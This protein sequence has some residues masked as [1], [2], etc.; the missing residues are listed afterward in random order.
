MDSRASPAEKRLER[1]KSTLGQIKIKELDDF[2]EHNFRLSFNQPR[3]IRTQGGAAFERLARRQPRKTE[4]PF[5]HSDFRGLIIP[6]YQE[7]VRN[8]TNGKLS[9]I[10]G[11]EK[12]TLEASL[13]NCKGRNR[14]SMTTREVFPIPQRMNTATG[15]GSVLGM[16]TND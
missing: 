12:S 9:M 13:H 15:I 7:A 4:N 5:M 11:G 8:C 1:A 16:R 6:D 3:P 2:R 14:K 10:S